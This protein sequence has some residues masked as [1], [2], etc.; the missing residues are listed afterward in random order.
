[1]EFGG[2]GQIICRA[3]KFAATTRLA[4]ALR[5]RPPPT[6]EQ[7]AKTGFVVVAAVLTAELEDEW[8]DG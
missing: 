7:P 2:N 6:E 3:N 1:M 8:Y 5:S 4:V